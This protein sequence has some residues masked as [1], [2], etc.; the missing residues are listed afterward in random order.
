M[1]KD[2]EFETSIWSGVEIYTDVGL[3]SNIEY[4][5]SLITRLIDNDST[6]ISVSIPVIPI[7]G[8]CQPGDVSG[9]NIVNILDVIELL[10][11]SL[12]YYE[13]TD[14]DYCKSDLNFDNILDI[15]DVLMLMDIIL[16]V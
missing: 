3:S 12:G 9:D 1:I 6:S 13:P 14:L 16:G 15:I 10:R 8:N 7:G 2:E 11:F 4:N 5:Y